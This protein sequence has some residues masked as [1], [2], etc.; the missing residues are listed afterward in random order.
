M[1]P[2]PRARSQTI[3]GVQTVLLALILGLCTF[4]AVA[5]FVDPMQG[6]RDPEL[7]TILLAVT[8]V[9]LTSNLPLAF[10]FRARGLRS[11]VQRREEVLQELGR[12]EMPPELARTTILAG[13]LVEG[14]G[15]FGSV[16]FFLSRQGVAL[17]APVLA[18]LVLL[19]LLP[20]RERLAEGV[21]G[22]S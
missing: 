22:A 11:A 19:F 1:T 4:V 12:G 3:Q 5:L 6:D 17:V 8:G 13:A 7:G 21:R 2:D 20:T 16:T 14:A 9:L 15:L 18:V 10:F